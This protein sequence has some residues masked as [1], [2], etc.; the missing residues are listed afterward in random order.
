MSNIHKYHTIKII[1]SS[2]FLI[3]AQN[4]ARCAIKKKTGSLFFMI[5]NKNVSHLNIQIFIYL[6]ITLPFITLKIVEISSYLII[7]FLPI[8]DPICHL[9]YIHTYI[10]HSWGYSFIRYNK[11]K[12]SF[13]SRPRK[14]YGVYLLPH[15]ILREH[16][17]LHGRKNSGKIDE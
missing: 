10:H 6:S 14:S 9:Y 3:W 12:I 16:W 15:R 11:T 1:P 8:S 7:F 5:W 4:A 13:N 2:P 17:M